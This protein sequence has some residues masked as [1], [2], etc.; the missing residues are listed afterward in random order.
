MTRM[1][2]KILVKRK[3]EKMIGFYGSEE[4]AK[5]VSK[6]GTLTKWTLPK[7]RWTL[8]AKSAADFDNAI[9]VINTFY[10]HIL[11]KEN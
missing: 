2:P 9:N 11:E 8:E 10:N 4:L 5:E 7:N 1:K 3:S 6:F